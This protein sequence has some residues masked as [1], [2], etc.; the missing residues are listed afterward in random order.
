MKDE[1][2]ILYETDNAKLLER[3]RC[4]PAKENKRRDFIRSLRVAVP[5]VEQ[6]P[7][8]AAFRCVCDRDVE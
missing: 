4:L 5:D 7:E 3:T 8:V 2:T 1:N 6:S